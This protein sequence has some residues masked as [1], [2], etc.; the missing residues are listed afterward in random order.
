M[1]DLENE[2]D[3]IGY[4]IVFFVV[5][6]VVAVVGYFIVFYNNDKASSKKEVPD[7]I[8]EEDKLNNYIGVWAMF[9]DDEDMPDSELCINIIDGSTLTFDY[10][11]K[12][13]LYFE[14][15]TA[16]IEKNTANFEIKDESSEVTL[17]G[18]IVFRNDKLFLILES[19][20]NEELSLGTF[21][22]TE[23]VDNSV[24]RPKMGE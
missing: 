13:T 18:K 3:R 15:E 16:H 22:Y 19:S 2:Q 4:W 5:V 7:I 1:E 12:N 14:S 6:L 10:Y 9:T 23:K 17:E 20:S 8:E 21:E 11:I 24:L